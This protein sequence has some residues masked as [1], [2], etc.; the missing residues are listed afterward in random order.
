MKNILLPILAML[1]FSCASDTGQKEQ[2]SDDNV[3]GETIDESGAQSLSQALTQL[4]TQDSI[5]TKIKATVESVCQ[6][7]GCWMNLVEADNE[8]F[9][10]FKDY[11]FFVPK[12]ISGRQVVVEGF[13]YREITSVDELRHYAEDEGKSEEEIAAITEPEEEYK[14]MADGVRLLP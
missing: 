8:I 14:F 5:R 11:G 3:F 12:D 7:K 9:V 10:K 6:K 1:F 4:G 13:A 2:K